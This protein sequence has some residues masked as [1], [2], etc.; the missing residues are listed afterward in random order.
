MDKT[1]QELFCI[2]QKIDNGTGFSFYIRI[3]KVSDDL[4]RIYWMAT[5]SQ[6]LFC[7]Y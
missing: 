7:I 4:G 6:K 3:R 5:I 1:N 2:Y